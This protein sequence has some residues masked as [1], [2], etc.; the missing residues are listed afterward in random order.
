MCHRTTSVIIL[1]R[2]FR[3]V[4]AI[5]NFDEKSGA[6]RIFLIDIYTNETDS[7]EKF[8]S[9]YKEITNA[10]HFSFYIILSNYA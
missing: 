6:R 9:F 2:Y 10:Q 7:F 8:L 3:K 5:F 4:T 1:S